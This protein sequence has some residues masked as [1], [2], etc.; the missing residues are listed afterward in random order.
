MSGIEDCYGTLICDKRGSCRLGKPCLN[1]AREEANDYHYQC[2]HLSVGD[3]QYDPG[4]DQEENVEKAYYSEPN[5]EQEDADIVLDGMVIPADSAMVVMNVLERMG[6]LYFSKP[7][8]FDALMSSIFKGKKQAD[9]AR[10]QNITRQ[11]VNKRLLS[12]LGI[13]QKRN[14]IQERRDRELAAAK[15]KYELAEQLEKEKDALI[16][17]MNQKEFSVYKLFFVDG[18][19]SRSVAKQLNIGQSTVMRTVRHLR[20]KLSKYGSVDDA[21]K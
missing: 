5:A 21:E 11:G 2:Q 19:S 15:L 20:R 7:N 14:D 12:E 6:E 10:D 18:C 17:E 13:A 16:R 1:H 4:E 9:I 3:I 8:A